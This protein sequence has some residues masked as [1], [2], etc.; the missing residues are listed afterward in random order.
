MSIAEK[1]T[2]VAENQQKVYDAG[3]S[4]GEGE[5]WVG[6]YDVGLEDGK[7][8]ERD[9]F[10]DA[11]Q[12]NGNRRN[13][14]YAF[15][16]SYW[17][18]KTFRPKHSIVSTV[19]SQI[20][21]GSAITDIGKIMKDNGV[22]FDF[23]GAK[24]TFSYTFYECET[25][26]LPTIDA[27]NAIKLDYTFGAMSNLVTIDKL[28]LG[29]S[30]TYTAPFAG[31]SKLENLIV[32]GTIGQNGFSVSSATRLTHESLMSI[33][34]ALADYSEDTSGTAW[35]VTLGSTNLAK[36]TAEEKAMAENK[37]WTLA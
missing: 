13:Y 12:G 1:L 18:D 23:S 7:S 24:A 27:S 21:R 32:E 33:I 8:L 16:S 5:G 2:T 6:G 36:L 34:N 17:N 25:A 3:R 19:A 22:A 4:R 14:N 26:T 15:Y 29:A 11:L 31:S 9:T 28:I 37:G 30:T 20:F 10:W 35:K